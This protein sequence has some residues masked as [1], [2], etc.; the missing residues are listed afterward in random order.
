MWMFVPPVCS[1]PRR[2]G[3]VGSPR[4]LRI[5]EEALVFSI[6]AR[7]VVIGSLPALVVWPEV[8]HETGT[9]KVEGNPVRAHSFRSISPSAA[10]HWN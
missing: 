4:L 2:Y 5:G 10:F 9:S 7:L 8:I 3:S 1:W 6:S